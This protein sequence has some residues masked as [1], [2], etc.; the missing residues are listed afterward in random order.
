M[1]QTP[2]PDAF[3]CRACVAGGPWRSY[4]VREMMFGS[5][6]EFL[7][8]ECARCGC[9][10]IGEVPIDLGRFA[11]AEHYAHLPEG[12]SGG[13][14]ASTIR[15]LRNGYAI[16]GR[17]VAGRFLNLVFSYPRGE[18]FRWLQRNGISRKSA[19][20]DVGCGT[21]GLLRDLEE[22]GY[23]E[24]MGVD[25]YLPEDMTLPEGTVIRCAGLQDLVGA[26]RRFDLIC[27]HHAFEHM[28][29]QEGTLTSVHHLLSA[30]GECVIRMPVVSSFAWEHYREDWVQLDAPRHLALHTIESM[31]MLA[32][33][34]GF[35]L[36]EVIYDSNEL[37]FV[38]SEMYQRDI[39]LAEDPG[40]LFSAKQKREFRR[41]A[42]DL[43]QVCR[44][45]SAAF[46]LRLAAAA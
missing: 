10:Q 33:R 4:R 16:D 30:G 20:L 13:S 34:T 43:N 39:A 17:G 29:D 35:E 8:L 22:V 5:R 19:I 45:D 38:G 27:L 2:V 3:R 9:L 26:A 32:E 24:L 11:P 21:G 28:G 14:V 31:R 23:S 36:V 12:G 41:R 42:E 6:E 46:V 44:G 40:D 18:V 1:E 37:Q 15:R 25:P 7:Y